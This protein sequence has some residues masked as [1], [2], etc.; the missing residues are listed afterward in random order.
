MSTS[1]SASRSSSEACAR[2]PCVVGERGG[3]GRIEVR[4]RDQPDLRVGEGVLGVAAGDVAGSDDADTEWGHAERLRHRPRPAVRR[5]DALRDRCPIVPDAT[6][7]DRAPA[8][9][10]SGALAADD[11][12]RDPA[13]RRRGR[14]SRR[15]AGG[16]ARDAPRPSLRGCSTTTA[17]EPIASHEGIERLRADAGAVAGRLAELGCPRVIVPWMPEDDRA[18]AADVRRFAAE[19]GEL[20]PDGL[21]ERRHP[22]RLSQPRF[23]VRAARRDDDLGRPPGR[24]P[25]R[26]R[27][28]ARRLLGVRRRPRPGGGDRGHRRPR[29]AAPHEGPRGRAD[30]ARCA[31][32]EGTLAFPAIIEAAGAAGVEWYIVEQDEPHDAVADIATAP[33]YLES[34]AR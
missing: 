4:R 14:L 5:R 24:A 25:A 31:G 29:P 10:A 28:R 23:R 2:Q 16:P 13:R 7:P 3:P 34:L 27:A 8:L 21:A 17:S 18:T 11:L 32:G 19:L 20:R 30:A 15:R 6:R 1:S 33:R 12:R 9:H 22:A 26:G